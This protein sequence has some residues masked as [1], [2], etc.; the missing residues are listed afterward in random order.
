MGQR[1]QDER[2]EALYRQGIHPYSISKLNAIDG[3]LREAYFTYMLHD[4]GKKN[5]Y[6]IMG[7]KI[8]DVLEHIYNQEA[9]G[10]DL[11]PALESELSDAAMFGVDFPKDFRGGDTIRNNWIGDMTHFCENF[12]LD[13]PG[14]P[15]T[16]Q[17][18]IY[19]VNDERYLIGYVDLTMIIDEEK[20]IVDI[21]DFKTSSL[22]KEKDLVSHG[23]QLVLYGMAMEQA[24]YKVRNLAW[25]MLKYVVLE[26]D[27]YKRIN[28]KNR[29]HITKIIPRHKI[30]NELRVPLRRDLEESG[31]SD[32]DIDVKLWETEEHL[33][34]FDGAQYASNFKF[35]NYIQYYPFT[36][37]NQQEVLNYIN[38]QADK[39][40]EL[41]GKPKSEWIPV[42]IGKGQEF[43]CNSL[44]GH[45]DHCET[46]LDYRGDK[47]EKED[48]ARDTDDLF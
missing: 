23:R 15:K 29:T 38:E 18:I 47:E 48:G 46:L 12:N 26:Y 11:L 8:H 40:E 36:E 42:E 35:N 9:T 17:L 20:K 32:M 28:S 14:I 21:Y 43:Y 22:F 19:K 33:N 31:M 24:G 1:K 44:C 39:F 3:C 6:G 4:R 7:S 27:G 34:E 16:E 30:W 41:Q 10:E 45:R 13:V 37:S 2:I 5:I 25:I